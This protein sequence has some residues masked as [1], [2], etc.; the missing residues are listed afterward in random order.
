MTELG[1]STSEVTGVLR[2]LATTDLHC[3]LL[4]RDYY[5]DRE[6]P[7]VGLSRLASLISGAR[8][9]AQARGG[10][11]LLLDNGDALQ[12]SPIGEAALRADQGLDPTSATAVHPLMSAFSALGYDALGLGNHDFNFG[13]PVLE[14]VLKDAPCAVVCSNMQAVAPDHA[15]PF[16]KSAI[17]E[18]CLD[19]LPQAPN[20]RIGILSV[21]P[22]QTMVWD[23]HLLEGE[24]EIQ[25]MV[26]AAA[27]SAAELR[28]AGC[29]LV[30]ALAHTGVGGE[31]AVPNMEN[32]LRPIVATTGIDAVIGGH[33]HL[34]LPD[35]E[36]AFAK[37]VVMPGAHGSHLGQIDMHL[38]YGAE[39]W[40]VE[41]WQASVVP[42]AR[43]DA[44]GKLSPLVAEDPALVEILAKA[45]AQTQARMKEP[46]GHCSKALHSYFI[47]FGQDHGLALTAC[48]QMAAVRPMLAGTQAGELPLL[49]AVSPGKFG[50]RSGPENYTDIA[51]GD[52]C[53]R[54]VADLQVFPNVIWGVKVN[55]DQLL[56]W[57]EMSAG[58]FN[59]ITPESRSAEL[60]NLD[61]AGHNFD[62]IFGLDYEI[63]V[64]QP[65]RFSSS[66]LL[67][68][69]DAH[70]VRNLCWNGVPVSS[71][72]QFS[73]ATNSYRVSG[74]GNFKMVQE[75][76]QLRLP[77]VKI[78][79]AIC[80]YVSGRLPT[81]ELA[82]APYPWRLRPL[83]GTRV[84]VYTGPVA[85]NYLDE[86]PAGQVEDQG[87]TPS[88][89]LK[90]RLSL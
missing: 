1:A 2:I 40:Q 55:G 79:D 52:L 32:A 33:T 6:D 80:D 51:A 27:A 18:R 84:S 35:P 70:R 13:L 11:T 53:M 86:L 30:I 69:P 54:N 22:P 3:N 26:Q 49:S 81:D 25:D 66:G 16:V 89:F 61:R 67:I 15:L 37:P 29:D 77:G 38:R 23:A 75:A 36:H 10:A 4:S 88:G 39:G 21:L 14:T 60:V 68:N 58:M 12:G 90:L 20:L 7:G 73:V 41:T 76:E 63:D 24:V 74:G 8:Q 83:P 9:E 44:W 56:E 28:A 31:F 43:R 85:R 48:A 72:Q 5:A 64:T 87:V 62:V 82:S 19:A 59:Q 46:V 47:F 45:D 34:V 78:R 65:P 71:T 17:V 50:G 42:I 57:L